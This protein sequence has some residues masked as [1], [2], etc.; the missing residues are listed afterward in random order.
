MGEENT[1]CP[2][3]ERHEDT[4]SHVLNCPVM[5]SIKPKLKEHILYEHIYG[6]IEQQIQLVR[7]YEKY[8]VLRD[9][10]LQDDEEYPAGL[11]GLH[12]GPMLRKGAA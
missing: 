12:A 9:T 3:C 5:L 11:P 7:E 1:L 10:L 2:I 6:N 4:Q 8:L